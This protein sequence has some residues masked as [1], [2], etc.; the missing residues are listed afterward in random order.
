[1]TDGGGAC[2]TSSPAGVTVDLTMDDPD[3]L[4][5]MPGADEEARK[6][7]IAAL[8]TTC[9]G[10]ELVVS[11]VMSNDRNVAT[12]NRRWRNIDG[13]TDVLSFP[14]ERRSPGRAPRGVA[15]APEGC[16]VELGDIVIARETLVRDALENVRP[17]H[18]H[19]AHIVVHGTLHLL[20]YGHETDD[21]AEVMETM[22]QTVLA[23]LGIPDPYR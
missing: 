4:V 7:C 5:D 22:E 17:L 1:M 11:L 21:D 2:S 20:G 16:A 6:A 15:G 19:L 13:P 8:E 14:S 12:L 9:P 18:D 3:W 23:G 10:S